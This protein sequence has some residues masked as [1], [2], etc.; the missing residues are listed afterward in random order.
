MT[1][2]VACEHYLEI[3]DLL[4]IVHFFQVPCK[5]PISL[6]QEWCAQKGVTSKFEVISVE[7]AV[8]APTFVYRVTVMDMVATATGQSKKKS[9]HSAAKAILDQIMG[10]SKTD[11]LA[12]DETCVMS[13]TKNVSIEQ[14]VSPYDDGIAGNPVGQLQE[15]CMER[16]WPPPIYDM[17]SEEGVPHERFF[18][19]VCKVGKVTQGGIYVLFIPAINPFRARGEYDAEPA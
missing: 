14:L 15:L 5:T 13:D 11:H 18:S 12:M 6:L 10:K 9:K 4:N 16:R 17:I 1:W 7:G 2:L 8:H 19:M 3:H